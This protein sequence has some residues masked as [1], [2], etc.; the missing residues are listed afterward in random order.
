[1]ALDFDLEAADDLPEDFAAGFG[2]ALVLVLA[3]GVCLLCDFS[4]AASVIV[5]T[6]A[7]VDFVAAAGPA[8]ALAGS[9]VAIAGLMSESTPAT[10]SSRSRQAFIPDAN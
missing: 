6:V 4:F 3:C 5:S 8:G 2:P 9:G 7:A 1:V 10:A